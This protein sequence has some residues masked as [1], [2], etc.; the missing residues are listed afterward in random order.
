MNWKTLAL[1]SAM[2]GVSMAGCGTT[3]ATPDGGNG[4]TDANNTQ[5]DANTPAQTITYVIGAIDTDTDDQA[6]AYGFDLD[7]MMDG[8]AGTC[9]D[10]AD[11]TSPVT[12]DTAVDN[13]LVNALSFLGSMLGDDGANG[14]IRDQIEAGKILLILQVS[15]INSFADDSSVQV[16]A[17][18][19]QVQQGTACHAHTAEADCTGD[20]ANSCDWTAA[21]SGTGGTC[22]ST[23]PPAVS[24]AC[25]AHT[26]EADCTGDAANACNWSASASTCSGIA[27]GQTFAVLQELD[28]VTGSI[29]G[30]RLTA[31]TS[32]LPLHFEASGMSIDL[33]L[34]EVHFG[35]RI[36]ATGITGG[37]FGAKV[38]VD[39][40]VMLAANLGLNVDRATIEGVVPP[41]LDPQAADPMTCD[42]ISAGMGFTAIT[43]TLPAN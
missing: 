2:A 11:Y 36:T 39:D 13:Q 1:C 32:Q 25:A 29:A 37:E 17:V 20:T 15:D 23:T 9:Q 6:Q 28:S 30:G 33:V 38:L 26:A 27:A 22:S 31:V 5:T 34:R 12:G 10:Q 43:A 7:G 18:L 21:A 3:A 40:V 41:D 8:P 19:G 42:A 35:G 16:R 14:A 24:T 4:T